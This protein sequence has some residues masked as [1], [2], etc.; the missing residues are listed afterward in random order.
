MASKGEYG[1]S[2]MRYFKTAC[3]T[4][5]FFV[6]GLCIALLGP[7]L[8]TLAHNLNTLDENLSFI[9][10]AR[11]CGYLIGSLLCALLFKRMNEYFLIAICLFLTA[12]GNFAVPFMPQIALLAIAVLVAGTSMGILDTGGNVLCLSLWGTESE[13]WMQTL[14]F[15]FAFGATLSPMLAKPFIMESVLA[16]HTTNSSTITP[17]TSTNAVIAAEDS[18]P[19]VAWAFIIAATLALLVSVIF[20][21]LSFSKH[22]KNASLQEDTTKLEGKFYRM[23]ILILLYWFYFLYVGTEVTFGLF[24]Y[25]FAIKCDM[26]YSKNTGTAL[27]SLFWGIFAI[28]RFCAIF[29]S[30]C[31]SPKSML[32]LDLLGT[33][34]ATVVM[35]FFPYYAQSAEWLLWASVALYGWSMAS[36][37]PSGITWAEHY[38]TVTEKAATTF[39]VGAS[40]GEM[41]LPFIMYHMIA[42]NPMNLMYFCAVSTGVSILIFIVLLIITG[43]QGS[44]LDLA[45]NKKNISMDEKINETAGEQKYTLVP[46]NDIDMKA[47]DNIRSS[48]EEI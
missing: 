13:P 18:F 44:R 41:A 42:R 16:D 38:I 19:L 12:L 10:T 7:S 3:L 25:T 36:L 2:W 40:L 43:K 47:D 30:K 24:I 1:Y 20:C 23:K 48:D 8:P 35:A 33:A 6:L 21:F 17:D 5:A 4:A 14:H 28:G 34:I 15:F 11:G 46:T 37:F 32:L 45:R 39:V 27:N 29:F 31:I 22:T 26:H 9:V